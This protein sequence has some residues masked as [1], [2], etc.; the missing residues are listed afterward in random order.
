MA[1]KQWLQAEVFCQKRSFERA[2]I[3]VKNSE[4][5]SK[6][7]GTGVSERGCLRMVYGWLKR[8]F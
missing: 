3:R 8:Y 5:L 6:K 1:G 7:S 4:E 2:K